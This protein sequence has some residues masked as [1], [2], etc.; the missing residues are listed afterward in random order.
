M[1]IN[2][3]WGMR[4]NTEFRKKHFCFNICWKMQMGVYLTIAGGVVILNLIVELT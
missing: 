1:I 3:V 4:N 2:V